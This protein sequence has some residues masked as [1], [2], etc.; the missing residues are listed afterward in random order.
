LANYFVGI[1]ILFLL[2]V[3]PWCAK[4]TL[5]VDDIS[6]QRGPAG[7]VLMV[8]ETLLDPVQLPFRYIEAIKLGSGQSYA[9]NFKLDCSD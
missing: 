3:I 6:F 5:K 9:V 2:F 4:Q 8:L 1:T 7:K